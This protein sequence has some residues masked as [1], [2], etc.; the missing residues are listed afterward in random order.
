M[1]AAQAARQAASA[2][3]RPHAGCSCQQAQPIHSTARQQRRL[4]GSTPK[5]PP[6]PPPPPC[7]SQVINKV[8]VHNLKAPVF[9][10]IMQ[11]MF[12]AT[13]VKGCSTFGVLEAEK[14]QWSLVRPFLLIVAGF[15]GTLFANIK[16]CS[17]ISAGCLRAAAAQGSSG[18]VGWN[19]CWAPRQHGSV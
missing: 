4:T 13:T 10:L 3:S 16:V 17:S 5:P 18:E 2:A 8:A 6:P 7:C 15:L 19:A 11:L 14:L 9:I 12:A 1:R